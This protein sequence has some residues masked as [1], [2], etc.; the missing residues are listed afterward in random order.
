[1][2]LN[3]K[4]LLRIHLYTCYYIILNQKSQTWETYEIFMAE[5]DIVG[6]TDLY[7]PRYRVKIRTKDQQ[8]YVS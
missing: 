3:I 1:M 4:P 5:Y 7:V 8:E 2:K 6:H